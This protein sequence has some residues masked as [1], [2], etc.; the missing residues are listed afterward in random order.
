ML[1]RC[2]HRCRHS[3]VRSKSSLNQPVHQSINQS[4]RHFANFNQS[5]AE[6][7][8]F[9]ESGLKYLQNNQLME[10]E[11]QFIAA[12]RCSS[13]IALERDLESSVP[14]YLSLTNLATTQRMLGHI[15]EAETNARRSIQYALPLIA[16]IGHD[17][18]AHLW[19]ELGLVCEAGQKYAEA[20][21]CYIKSADAYKVKLD[22][23]IKQPKNQSNDQLT[24]LKKEYSG[25]LFAIAVMSEQ[26]ADQSASTDKSLDLYNQAVKEYE[27]SYQVAAD[28]YGAETVNVAEIH[29]TVG[30]CL[31]KMSKH[32][33]LS[34]DQSPNSSSNQLGDKGREELLKA[35]E[36]YQNLK[37]PKL[38]PVLKLYL[39]SMDS[40]A[41][42]SILADADAADA[43]DKPDTKKA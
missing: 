24:E 34:Q 21:D 20:K 31:L 27:H 13:N 17:T 7:K 10:A 1:T 25:S 43:Q 16:Q 5:L 8:S 14:M 15:S 35:L 28:A 6:W 42:D 30:K 23:L 40:A 41:M 33:S 26:I 9:N 29:V 37:D 12:L 32:H 2:A 19:R 4:I 3:I 38:I 36:I 39:S 11:N 18:I 22:A